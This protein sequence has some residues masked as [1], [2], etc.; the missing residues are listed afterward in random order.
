MNLI[1]E[2]IWDEFKGLVKCFLIVGSV[3]GAYSFYQQNKPEVD[4][5]IET[6]KELARQH[7]KKEIS[8]VLGTE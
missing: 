6:A 4:N 7:V 5:N 1:K 2:F 8:D 3:F